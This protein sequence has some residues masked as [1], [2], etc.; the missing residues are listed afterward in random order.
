MFQVFI[1]CLSIRFVFIFH[2]QYAIPI[3]QN[4][5]ISL[6]LRCNN[7][8]WHWVLPILLCILETSL[9]KYQDKYHIWIFYLSY[10]SNAPSEMPAVK[11]NSGSVSKELCSPLHL[12]FSPVPFLNISLQFANTRKLVSL[13]KIAAL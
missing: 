6:N 7:N 1:Y 2:I 3:L 4:I 8:L 9:D 11:D 5:S 12:H 10:G 13:C